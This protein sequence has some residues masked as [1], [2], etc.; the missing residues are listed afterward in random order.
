M[1]SRFVS[2]KGCS[3][4]FQTGQEELQG[5]LGSSWHLDIGKKAIQCTFELANLFAEGVV[6]RTN[7]DGGEE[8]H[9]RGKVHGSR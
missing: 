5:T 1:D 2:G 3:V 4:V 6:G 8:R 7:L 9:G